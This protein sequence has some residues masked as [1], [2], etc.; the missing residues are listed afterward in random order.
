MGATSIICCPPSSIWGEG[1]A[2]W[3]TSRDL[4]THKA[5][6][7]S[8]W[9]CWETPFLRQSFRTHTYA[10][11]GAG[12]AFLPFPPAFLAFGALAFLGALVA[13]FTALGFA[14]FLAPLAGMLLGCWGGATGN[15][16]A[17]AILFHSI[18]HVLP[19]GSAALQPWDGGSGAGSL[20]KIRCCTWKQDLPWLKTKKNPAAFWHSQNSRLWRRCSKILILCGGSLIRPWC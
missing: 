6:S 11:A 2:I 1:A 9:W 19:Q 3:H 10:W 18:Q 12:A 8:E 4:Q 14:A 7:C 5:H 13:F 16:M 20:K 15:A 17:L